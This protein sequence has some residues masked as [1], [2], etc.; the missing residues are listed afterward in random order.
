MF[1]QRAIIGC[2]GRSTRG[3]MRDTPVGLQYEMDIKKSWVLLADY[4]G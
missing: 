3:A 2:D 4:G 1:G